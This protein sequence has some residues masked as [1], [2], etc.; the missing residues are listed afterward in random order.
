MTIRELRHITKEQHE[1][2]QAQWKEIVFHA[3]KQYL[4]TQQLLLKIAKITPVDLSIL[5]ESVDDVLKNNFTAATG[6]HIPHSDFDNFNA[7]EEIM[8]TYPEERNRRENETI[9][10]VTDEEISEF[11]VLTFLV[12]V[13]RIVCMKIR[14]VDS[15][16]FE[17]LDL[18]ADESVAD[19]LLMPRN[20]ITFA[21]F[22][23]FDKKSAQATYARNMQIGDTWTF[24]G[25]PALR[26][27]RIA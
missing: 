23:K 15:I 8:T 20:Y 6:G 24:D 1:D 22:Y 17:V 10:P 14:Y 16:H 3:N 12:V 4:L 25:T 21:E 19:Q 7:F 18:N 2:I 13:A 27:T 26:I 11:L 5:E 9:E